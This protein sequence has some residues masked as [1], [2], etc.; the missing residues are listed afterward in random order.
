MHTFAHD[1]YAKHMKVVVL[2]Y[3]RPEFNY[4]NRGAS[5]TLPI[6]AHKFEWCCDCPVTR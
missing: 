3:I 2:G 6:F 4:V 1:F 5:S